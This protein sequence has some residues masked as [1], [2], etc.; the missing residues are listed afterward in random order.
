[1]SKTL[2]RAGAAWGLAAQLLSAH[3]TQGYQ[4][5]STP[6]DFVGQ[7]VNG[8]IAGANADVQAY[9]D[10]QTAHV[11][12]SGDTGYWT[13]DFTAPQGT[14]L[15]AGN[16]YAAVHRYPFNSP[17]A[18]GMDVNG[19]GGGCNTL[20]GWFN[21]LEYKLDDQ[22]NLKSLA[23]D[24]VQNCEVTMPPLY[25][26]V[27]VASQTPL[28]VP[29][30][31]AVAGR[32]FDMVAG[33]VAWL[34]G[35]QSFT[36]KQGGLTYQWTQ[37][38]GPSVVLKNATTATPKFKAPKVHP[39]GA[40]LQFHLDVTDQT[41]RTAGDDVFVLVENPN[42]PRTQLQVQGD[43]GDFVTL[44]QSYNFD[45]MNAKLTFSNNIYGGVTLNIAGDSPWTFDVAPP[46]GTTL[47]PG[48]YQAERY[49]FEKAGLAGLDFYGDG[50]GCNT[51]I[52]QFTVYQ[53][54]F[55]A[56][57]QPSKLD[58]AFEQHCEGGSPA[59]RGEVLLNAVP[60][61]TIAARLQAARAAAG[62]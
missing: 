2:F 56:A 28:A 13:F 11:S 19:N 30:I 62:R 26:S 7:G 18:A 20:L 54:E 41:G 46:R 51:V 50:R 58:I 59:S 31:A 38:A 57:G 45:A 61:Q 29:V 40:T 35:T 9:G 42:D 8:T 25:G 5:V 47:Q 27:R 10:A 60:Q 16:S 36:R 55:D 24:F 23:I 43:T 52:G 21:V 32:D 17:A 48:T 14:R 44:G 4:Y 22:G 33:Q 34:D 49:P 1:M 6:G 53:A 15:H 12:I 39:G 37:V 3:A